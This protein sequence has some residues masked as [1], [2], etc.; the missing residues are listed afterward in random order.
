LNSYYVVFNRYPIIIAG[1]MGKRTNE[2]WLADLR[3]EG[4]EKE[5]ALEDLRSVVIAGL[6]YALSTWLSPADPQFEALVEEVAQETLIRALDHL[7]TFEGR[8]QFTTWVQKIAVRLALTEL[9]RR[10]W[11]D[12]S[13]DELVEEKEEGGTFPSLLWDPSPNPDS[14][15]EQSDT[16]RRVRQII[17]EELTDK[18]RM[19]MIGIA[20]RGAPMEEVASRLGTNR[21]ALYKLLHDARLKLKRRLASEG[22]DVEDIYASFENK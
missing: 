9:R 12:F 7:D 15:I 17:A 5:A 19:A 18:Q 8:S 16:L 13:L 4:L 10:K 14:L 22:L 6:P 20:V 11:R 21:N 2:K 1:S 3:S